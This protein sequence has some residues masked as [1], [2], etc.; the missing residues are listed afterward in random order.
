MKWLKSLALA[1]TTTT[2]LMMASCA[3]AISSYSVSNVPNPRLSD[4]SQH[5]SDPS[6]IL[7]QDTVN[8]INTAL[9]NLEQNNGTQVAV[10]MLP[11]IGS[12][13]LFEFSH[14]LFRSWGIGH[15]DKNDGLLIVYVED[16]HE[17]RFHTGYGIEG[18]LS[19]AICKRIQMQQMIPHFKKGETDEGMIA[20]VNAVCERIAD[21]EKAKAE[22]KRQAQ[23][24]DDLDFTIAMIVVFT[25]MAI[26]ITGAFI[27][28]FKNA[29]RKCPKCGMRRTLRSIKQE[30]V[31]GIRR[32]YLYVTKQ[33]KNC[34]Y[35]TVIKYDITGRSD[36]SSSG[37]F[38]S[39]FGGGGSG[40]GGG[41]GG[42]SSGGGGSSSSW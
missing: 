24:E 2:M 32:N 18:I 34:G 12:S 31:N 22:D 36:N 1:F 29:N 19:D 23:E 39:G 40:G 26:I 25:V 6:S 9:T 37:G 11:S 13:D 4:Y 28:V 5:V 21:P 30:R 38:S 41:Y 16:K 42:G 20:G 15:K 8:T 27:C 7:K 10:V 35:E 3:L 33:C 14:E 17:I